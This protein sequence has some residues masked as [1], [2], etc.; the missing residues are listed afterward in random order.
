[1]KKFILLIACACLLSCMPVEAKT[2]T[3]A[4]KARTTQVR[5]KRGMSLEDATYTFANRLAIDC[6]GQLS[7]WSD[8]FYVIKLPDYTDSELAKAYLD[9]YDAKY[10]D[11]QQLTAWNM[12]NECYVKVAR[13][14]LKLVYYEYSN[15]ISVIGEE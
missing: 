10:A 8:S 5:K 1:M 12:S 11:I 13:R 6:G 3:R 4:R 14:L 9:F 7:Y 15:E 2:K